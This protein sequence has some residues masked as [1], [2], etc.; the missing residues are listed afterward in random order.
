MKSMTFHY[1]QTIIKNKYAM[2]DPV[3]IKIVYL[4]FL[5]FAHIAHF[6]TSIV[7]VISHRILLI[8]ALS[9]R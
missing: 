4:V 9:I 7:V 6:N 8:S 1:R 5:F 2:I 3:I